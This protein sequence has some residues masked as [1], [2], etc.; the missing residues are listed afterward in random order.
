MKKRF[1]ILI[2]VALVFTLTISVSYA[3]ISDYILVHRNLINIEVNGVPAE[4]DNFLFNG[5]TYVQ[6]REISEMLNKD[7]GWNPDTRVASINDKG[8]QQ[9]VSLLPESVGFTWMYNGFAEYSHQMT[10]KDID[11]TNRGLEFVINGEVGDP[12]DGESTVDRNVNIKYV[13]TNNGIIQEKTEEGMLDSK[14][15]KI[16]LIRTP[17]IAG[18]QWTE[19]VTDNQGGTTTLNAFIQKVEINESG[20]KEFTVRYNDMNSEYY[21]ERLIRENIGVVSFEKLMELPDTSFP[22]SYFLFNNAYATEHQIT[23]YFPD[24]NGEKLHA[25]LRNIFLTDASIAR[26]TIEELIAGPSSNLA[27][28]IPQGTSL[29]SIHI[30]DGV[31]YVDLSHEFVDNH[32]GG[33]TNDIMTLYSIVNT[34]TEF[35]TIEKVQILVEGEIGVTFGNFVLDRPFERQL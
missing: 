31:C 28:S 24:N 1:A 17:L 16:T 10:L 20:L 23:L 8:K 30:E 14:Y 2:A 7:V 4:V 32:T 35:H 15:D 9:L 18:N 22:V 11:D 12:S 29:L 25:E 19:K 6:L 34:L 21:E 5:R 27:S 3:V 33:S 13:V 26:T